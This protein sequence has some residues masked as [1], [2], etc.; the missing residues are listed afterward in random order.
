MYHLLKNIIAFLNQEYNCSL[1][2]YLLFLSE[3]SKDILLNEKKTL[4]NE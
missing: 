4:K 1:F 3:I 2:N